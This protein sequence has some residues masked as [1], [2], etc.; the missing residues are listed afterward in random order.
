MKLSQGKL[1][2]VRRLNSSDVYDL[3]CHLE[4]RL[5]WQLACFL[6]FRKLQEKKIFCLVKKPRSLHHRQQAL[7]IPRPNQPSWWSVKECSSDIKRLSEDSEMRALEM[8]LWLSKSDRSCRERVV[9][10]W[11]KTRA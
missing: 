5:F 6:L 3:S 11:M 2:L 1:T 7:A 9:D 4:R 10:S 8:N